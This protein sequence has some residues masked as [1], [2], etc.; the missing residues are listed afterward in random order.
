MEKLWGNS[1]IGPHPRSEPE[2]RSQRYTEKKENGLD[3][4]ESFLSK[5][6]TP[7]SADKKNLCTTVQLK[8]CTQM[9]LSH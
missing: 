6:L 9:M 3:S 5:L 1:I 7:P 2:L 8:D 4:R